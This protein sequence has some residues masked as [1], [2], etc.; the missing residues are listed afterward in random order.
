MNQTHKN[1]QVNFSRF[2]MVKVGACVPRVSVADVE[3]NVEE[4]I[5]MAREA[6]HEGV[7]LAVFPEL[8]LTGYTC[9]D[10]F[11]Q[12]L[13][14]QQTLRGI[15]GLCEAYSHESYLPAI[16]VG[17]PLRWSDAV[18]NCAVIIN[19]GSVLGVVPKI[20]IPNY[21]EF[22][23]KRWFKSG[24]GIVGEKINL[25]TSDLEKESLSMQEVPFGTD[26]IF[27]ING[28]N[29]GVEICE[30]LWVPA[31]PSTQLCQQ[32]AD[33]IVNLSASDDNIGKHSY[34]LSL[35]SQQSAR[36]RCAYVY[37]SAGWGE[38]STDLSF[39][40]NAVIA[41]DGTLVA[42]SPRFRPEAFMETAVVD[43]ELLRNERIKYN[44]YSDNYSSLP[45]IRLIEDSGKSKIC[46]PVLLEEDIAVNTAPFVP[47]DKNHLKERCEEI[48]SIQAWGLMQRLA[49]TG[50]KRAVIG[51]S[52]GLDSTLALLVTVKAFDKL[53]IERENIVAVT[54]PGFG[55][56]GRTHDNAWNL[57]YELGVTRFEIPIGEAVRLHFRDIEHNESIHDATYENGQA[58]ERT[59]ILMDLANKYGG[60]VIGT[61]DL[62]ELAL[63]WCTYNGDQMSMYGVNASI[64]K[65]LVRYL[66]EW[67]AH[68][69]GEKAAALLRDIIDTPIS[70]ELIPANPDGSIEQK[71]EDLVGPY[72]L[73][74]F[75]LFHTLR[76]GFSPEKIFLL[77][78]IAFKKRF[79]PEV[80]LKWQR[81]FY[82]RFFSQQFKRSAM[83]DGPKVGSVCLSPRG[84][85]RMPSDAK[86]RMWLAEMDR[87][88]EAY[89]L[90]K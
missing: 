72:D 24:S 69:A 1:Y 61:G 82:R 10:L 49:A 83:P 62:S 34:L 54:M 41:C 79:S 29:V 36:C 9:A 17:A 28:M 57:M 73:H 22:Y 39:C 33:V 51:I 21:A 60:M 58:R 45:D 48:T 52:G 67:H 30:D 40:G 19:E 31:P 75:F 89:N 8:S 3:A 14:L 42:T 5:R 63:G 81:T 85:W 71:T 86:S 13:L 74:D 87:L 53:G 27:N 50:C 11:S 37:A 56:T 47:S 44:S 35:V 59:Q 77:A 20:Y 43:I 6:G 32:G 12:D 38:S 16:V 46:Y 68:E 23:E 25:S 80:I 66:V 4:I 88:A 90:E 65:S 78:K 18:Y 64:P 15:S 7:S 55:T 26:L 2:G 70:P 76:N 84:D